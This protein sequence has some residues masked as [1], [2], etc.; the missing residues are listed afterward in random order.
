MTRRT[1]RRFGAARVAL[2]L[3]TVCVTSVGLISPASAHGGSTKYVRPGPGTP[4]QKA[5]DA[6]GPG[7]RILV[8]RGTY[9][10]QLTI[11]KDGISLVGLGAILVPPPKPGSND[12]SGLAG[13]GTEAGICV[14]GSDLKFADFVVEHREV[15]SVG[16]RVE[17]V[18]ITGFQVRGFSGENIAVVG[19]QD[20][21]VTGNRLTDGTRYG[22]L[23]AGSTNTRI[24]AN[25][26]NTTTGL[27]FIGVCMDDV[28]GVE[29]SY[30]H[31]SGYGTALCVQTPGA[32]VQRNDV[33]DNCT[34]VY[35]D[36]GVDGARIHDNHITGTNRDCAPP[37]TTPPTLFYVFGI[38]LA[39]AVNTQVR[40]NRIEGQTAP[41]PGGF[42]AG[43]AVFD[44]PPSPGAAVTVA[45]GNVVAQNF[46]RNNDVD[47]GLSS[48]G[49]GNVFTQNKCTIGEPSELCPK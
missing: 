44:W 20:A 4:I 14:E 13:A 34:G 22:F 8:G 6:A 5:I 40:H 19:A 25:T 10:E 47:L 17:D 39:G 38:A 41:A 33:S 32:E 18:S 43:I 7:D 15:L 42:A 16:R 30:N 26:V 1:S 24:S 46:L 27:Q 35:V 23:T 11:D 3:A 9:A 48:G 2:I 21:R 12:C 45:S 37:P 36:P 29:V 31:I 49:T 28:A